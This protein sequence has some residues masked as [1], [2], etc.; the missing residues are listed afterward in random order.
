MI[1]FEAIHFPG[2]TEGSIILYAG[3][4]EVLMTGDAAMGPT[5]TAT[6][7]GSEYL[8]RPPFPLMVSDAQLRADWLAFNRPLNTVLPFHGT[9]YIERATDLPRIMAALRREEPTTSMEG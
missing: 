8:I 5:A 4:N 7:A 3:Q 6:Q 1:G 9:G 2:H